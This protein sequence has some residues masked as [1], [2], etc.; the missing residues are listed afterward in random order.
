M[1][2][3]VSE[4]VCECVCVTACVYVWMP[5]C[6]MSVCINVSVWR[7]MLENLCVSSKKLPGVCERVIMLNT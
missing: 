7:F 3:C 6:F 5:N 4:C 2:V 1:C